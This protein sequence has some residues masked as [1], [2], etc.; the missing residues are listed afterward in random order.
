M[1]AKYIKKPFYITRDNLKNLTLLVKKK[2]I[3]NTIGISNKEKIKN[4]H[5]KQ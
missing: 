5:E 3:I 2:N 1:K 4:A